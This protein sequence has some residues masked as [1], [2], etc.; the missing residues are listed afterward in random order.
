MIIAVDA[1]GGDNAPDE[2][3]KGSIEAAKENGVKIVLVGDP[4][5]IK[6]HLHR[7][8]TDDVEISIEPSSEVVGMDEHPATAV[9]KKK[10][11]SIVVATKLV[12]EGKA[13]AIVSAGSTGA[14]MAAALF[15][16]KRIKG[17]ERPAIVTVLPTLKGGKILLDV[18]A[19]VDSKSKNLLQ[20]AQMGSVYAEKILKI[21]SPK[22]AL[23]NIGEEETK[24][25]ELAQ[26]SYKL[27]AQESTI[28]FTGNIEGRE[29]LSGDTDVMVC[30]G[31]L[32]NVVL[33]FAEGMAA[34][35]F[36]ILKEELQQSMRT[37]AGAALAYPAFK[38]IKK[39]MDYSE[40][41]G[42]PLLGVNGVSIICHGSSNAKA[43]KN[44]I[45][46]AEECV[47]ANFIEVISETI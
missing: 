21:P 19:N 36:G 32:G 4:Q 6:E 10:D 16:L 8:K 28:N 3:I 2:I 15:G 45:G 38:A 17:I 42:A 12:R 22:V 34:T 35:I 46:V 33:K 43:I 44:A 25:N 13:D 18:G 7:H 23:V 1:M 26:E 11:S 27:M 30:D 47:K 41:G 20:F 31:F 24:G 14:Q 40:Y 39:K 9:R 5:V 37:K 29:L